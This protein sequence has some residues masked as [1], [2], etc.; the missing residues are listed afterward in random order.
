MAAAPDRCAPDVVDLNRLSAGDLDALLA[1]EQLTWRSTLS[2][3]FSASA[4]LV[5]RF[6]AIHALTGFALVA[7]TQPVGYCYYVA[8]DRKGLIGDLYLLRDWATPENEDVLLSA[9]LNAL[10][11]GTGVRRIEAQLMMLHGPFERALPMARHGQIYPR[12]FMQADL[13]EVSRLPML[14]S[15]AVIGIESWRDEYEDAGARVIAAAYRD[16]VD[17]NINDQYR[18]Y[19]GARKFLHNIVHYPGCGSFFSPA[20]FAATAPGGQVFG[21]SL[22]SLV[23]ADVGHITQICVSPEWRGHGSGYELMRHSLLALTQQGC[24]RAS[25]TVTAENHKAIALY[26]EMGFRALRRFAAY[27]WE[28]Q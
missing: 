12:I 2:W 4:A 18:S 10:I 3:D 7:G 22:A 28:D 25:L 8:E 6:L 1:E 5:R 15:Q 26:N 9:A 11:S 17:S 23:A 27:V 24:E 13:D 20:S 21:I 19:S 14:S 16:H